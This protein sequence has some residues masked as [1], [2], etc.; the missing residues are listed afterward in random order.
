METLGPVIVIYNGLQTG[1]N[2]G[3][4]QYELKDFC[5]FIP[6]YQIGDFPWGLCKGGIILQ[7]LQSEPG[8][9]GS[10]SNCH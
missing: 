6:S 2:N 9:L 10:V 7:L 8:D 4:V 5:L 3:Q 1:Q